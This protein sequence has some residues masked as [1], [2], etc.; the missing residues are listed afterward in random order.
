MGEEQ[1][2][3]AF[4]SKL[5]LGSENAVL[6][7][8]GQT[9]V[10]VF[11]RGGAD[12]L[13]MVA[14]YADPNYYKV[15]PTIAIPAP[16]KK[17]NS[18]LKLDDFYAFHPKLAPLLPIFHSGELG[19]V[20]GVGTDNPTGSHFDAQ[21][22][23]EH[24]CAYGTPVNGGWLGRYLRTRM[25]EQLTPL[26]AVA[27]GEVIPES[28][29]GSPVTT[30]IRRIEEIHMDLP[31]ADH[32]AVCSALSKMYSADAGILKEPGSSTIQLLK[33]VE[34][35]KSK[36]YN[37]EKGAVYGDERFAQGLKE[38][39]RLIKAEVGLE[40]ACLDLDGW[41][42]HFFQGG[43]EG[44]HAALNEQLAKG[45]AAFYGDLHAYNHRVTTIAITEFGRRIYE[46]GSLGTDHGRG[47]AFFA[48]GAG[49]RGGKIYG[50][51]PGLQDDQYELGPGGMQI[52]SDYRSVLA[53]ILAWR[54]APVDVVFPGVQV[55]NSGL[56]A[57]I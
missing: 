15:R 13:N 26:S 54:K 42:T 52:T 57:S 10:C 51:Y 24:G 48:M 30:A 45:L 17:P 23:M 4:L 12:T 43:A 33:R 40:V 18:G 5:V 53:E 14:P 44:I 6:N 37:P 9:L 16:G 8:G 49:V 31:P 7:P 27:I 41:D 35:F 38:I 29:R 21:D 56:I 25:N 36:T 47:F 3:R 46:N 28:F 22:Q 39:A 50:R 11:L 1:S 2:R 55:K 19:I 32:D 20:Q 34:K